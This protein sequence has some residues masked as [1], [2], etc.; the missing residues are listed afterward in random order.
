MI[1][2]GTSV[3]AILAFGYY[4][5][6]QNTSHL[7][8]TYATSTAA[9]SKICSTNVL[10]KKVELMERCQRMLQECIADIPSSGKVVLSDA[11]GGCIISLGAFQ[12]LE[13]SKK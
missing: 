6:S 7:R 5:K 12:R 11:P 13:K 2:G 1:A 8:S 10:S 9:F 3:L 4:M